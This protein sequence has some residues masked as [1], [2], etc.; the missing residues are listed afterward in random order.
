MRAAAF[1]LVVLA[2]S[3]AGTFYVT[4]KNMRPGTRL[5][6]WFRASAARKASSSWAT[7]L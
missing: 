7:A 6:A 3:N 2:L 4:T 5:K 1:F